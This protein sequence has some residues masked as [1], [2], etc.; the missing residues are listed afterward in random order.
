MII[1]FIFI[2]FFLFLPRPFFFFCSLYSLSQS[3]HINHRCRLHRLLLFG[4]LLNF[5]LRL[6]LC[7]TC[8]AENLG[9]LLYCFPLFLFHLWLLILC[10]LSIFFFLVDFLVGFEF[11]L[12]FCH[13]EL[14]LLLSHCVEAFLV[15]YLSQ[16]RVD[17]CQEKLKH[18]EVTNDHDRAKVKHSESGRIAVCQ[19]KDNEPWINLHCS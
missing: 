16:V 17:N 11:L 1:F 5:P 4:F 3:T 19:L 12:F 15:E 10:F 9:Q 13:L 14:H 6:G 8:H 7:S 2:S 18:V